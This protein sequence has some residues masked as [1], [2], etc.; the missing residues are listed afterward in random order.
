[1]KS[2]Y[3]MFFTRFAALF[4]VFF[5]FASPP[6]TSAEEGKK[7]YFV[8]ITDTH[9]G[10]VDH[11]DVLEKITDQ[12]NNLPMPVA[13]I[14][15]TG[16]IFADNITNEKTFA[17]ATSLISRIKIPLM[18]LPGNHDLPKNK[19]KQ[20]LETYKK[21]GKLAEKRE[22]NGVVFITLCTEPLSSEIKIKDYDPLEW[23]EKT[24]KETEKKPVLLFVHVPPVPDFYKNKMHDG[25]PEEK[26]TKFYNLL[27]KYNVQAVICGHFH[28]DELHWIG[29]IPIYVAPPAARF[30]DRQPSFRI[31]E[32]KNGKLDY[33]TVYLE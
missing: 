1:M 18:L 20:S 32:N 17:V 16:D 22:F 19:Q 33:F 10:V 29:E 4:L 25:W 31:Y 27:K 6:L 13:C 21:I 24:L 8:Q 30:Y 28:R 2:K 9:L 12:I 7:F 15:H 23:L 14:V 5:L 3:K 26:Y 11:N